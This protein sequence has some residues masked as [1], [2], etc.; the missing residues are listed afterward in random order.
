[1]LALSAYLGLFAVAFGAATLLPFQSEPL[2]VGLLLSGE[3]ST[4]GLVAVASFGNVLGAVCNWIVGLFIDRIHDRP[5]FPVKPSSLERASG[6]YRRY[7][8]WSLLLSWMP[9]FGDALT[10]LAGVLREPLWSFL[11]LV[12]IAKTGR[13]LV[14]AAATLGTKAAFAV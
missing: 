4:L 3:F 8:R 7:G 5:W 2:L 10:V 11:L 13:Y 9:L 1:M 14:L 6:W 12:T